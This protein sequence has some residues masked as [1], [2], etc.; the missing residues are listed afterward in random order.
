MRKS[1]TIWSAILL[2]GLVVIGGC[3]PAGGEIHLSTDLNELS[4]ATLWSGIAQNTDFQEETDGDRFR[5]PCHQDDQRRRGRRLRGLVSGTG[6][7]QGRQ[8]RAGGYQIAADLVPS[9]SLRCTRS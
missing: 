3:R 1:V 4:L 5:R 2:L 9:L 7:G 8:S 6:G